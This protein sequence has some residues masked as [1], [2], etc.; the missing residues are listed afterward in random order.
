MTDAKHTPPPRGEEPPCPITKRPYFMHIEHPDLGD[1]PTYGGP[2]DSYTIPEPDEDGNFRSE[3]YCHDR[4]DWVEGGNPEGL[5]L[6]TE[7]EYNA[8]RKAH[9]AL[10][11]ERDSAVAQL[12][13]ITPRHA[14][15]CDQR[16][17]LVAENTEL[18]RKLR[19]AIESLSIAL[20]PPTDEEIAAAIKL[21][22]GES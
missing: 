18:R 10:V 16:N 5:M 12:A 20:T 14:S 6:V 21:A 17:A 2:F 22:R 11:A 8:L 19:E 7:R 1:V 4:G 9:D 3:H 15:L 13:Y